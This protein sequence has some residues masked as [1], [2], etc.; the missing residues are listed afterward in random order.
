MRSLYFGKERTVQKSG[1]V[2]KSLMKD[3]ILD[4]KKYVVGL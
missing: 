2:K 3:Y 4:K 1:L